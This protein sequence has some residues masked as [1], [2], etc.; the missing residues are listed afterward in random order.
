MKFIITKFFERQFFKSVSDLE[1]QDLISRI[2]VESKIFIDLRCPYFKI[3][4]KSKSKTYRLLVVFDKEDSII[5]FVNI[6]DKKDKKYW[7][8]LNWNLHKKD[9]IWWRDKSV[10]CIK[11]WDYYKIEW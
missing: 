7:E 8:N 5:L 6:F 10:V 3:K 11:S 9:I 4:I 1:I 2:K